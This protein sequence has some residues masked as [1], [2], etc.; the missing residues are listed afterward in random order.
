MGRIELYTFNGKAN[1]LL[2]AIRMEMDMRWS[3]GQFCFLGHSRQINAH[4]NPKYTSIKE[5]TIGLACFATP[6]NGG[7]WMLVEPRRPLYRPSMHT[8]PT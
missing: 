4:N 2:K 6:R 3:Q 7:D 8:D 1:E 5:A